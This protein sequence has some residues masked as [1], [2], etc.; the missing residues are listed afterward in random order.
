MP[1]VRVGEP[2]YVAVFLRFRFKDIWAALQTVKEAKST[3][4]IVIKGITIWKPAFFGGE[5]MKAIRWIMCPVMVILLLA[6]CS[7][8]PSTEGTEQEMTWQDY[9]DLGIRYLSEGNYEEAIIAF[10]AA[11]EI[12]SRQSQAY[13][14]RGAAYAGLAENDRAGEAEDSIL[15]Y[16]KAIDD[17]LRAIAL[18]GTVEEWYRNASEIYRLLDDQES[19]KDVLQKGII[20]TNSDNL[21]SI[22]DMI[23]GDDAAVEE[24]ASSGFLLSYV[25]YE[26]LSNKDQDYVS[27]ALDYMLNE[28]IDG[29][30]KLAQTVQGDNIFNTIADEYK[31]S[32]Q[33]DEDGYNGTGN[34]ILSF[35]SVQVRTENGRGYF[36]RAD[37]IDGR[38][39]T[40]N[41]CVE[42]DM[43][44]KQASFNCSHWQIDGDYEMLEWG[45]HTRTFSDGTSKQENYRTTCAGAI[46]DNLLDGTVIEDSVSTLFDY[47]TECHY[48]HSRIYDSGRLISEDGEPVDDIR[49]CSPLERFSFDKIEL[50]DLKWR[51]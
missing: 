34:G 9:Y 16:R 13:A 18:D 30:M 49:I 7:G 41:R 33:Y 2:P 5:I 43:D 24:T 11:I 23:N 29:V 12:D 32:I 15:N 42:R 36:Y 51:W 21:R 26:D 35:F 28:N 4:H 37:M 8:T 48:T 19:A 39:N 47:D 6:A 14:G 50:F 20:A 45:E 38:E 1:S 22:L 44:Y 10:S 3:P 40:Y 25:R 46:V 17:Y 27:E 31:V